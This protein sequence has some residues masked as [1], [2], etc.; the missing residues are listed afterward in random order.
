MFGHHIPSQSRGGRA[1]SVDVSSGIPIVKDFLHNV[2]GFLSQNYVNIMK[3]YYPLD[4]AEKLYVLHGLVL[5]SSM[6]RQTPNVFDPSLES[7]F[8][9]N[10]LTTSRILSVCT[11]AGNPNYQVDR[12]HE[13]LSR[14][15]GPDY[16]Y[17]THPVVGLEQRRLLQSRTW[18][19]PSL[20]HLRGIP[21]LRQNRPPQPIVESMKAVFE[22]ANAA[23]LQAFFH[24]PPDSPYNS[25]RELFMLYERNRSEQLNAGDGTEAAVE[26]SVTDSQ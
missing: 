20:V 18:Y 17:Q 11:A 21:S 26:G 5:K 14:L 2:E 10:F 4:F 12:T 23:T 16:F 7:Y 19:Q 6:R 25:S 22:W 8:G 1:S 3:K 9:G 24:T 13:I 15:I